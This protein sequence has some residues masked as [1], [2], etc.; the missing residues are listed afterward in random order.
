MP[1]SI[2]SL[3]IGAIALAL[4]MGTQAISAA[5]ADVPESKEPI[6]IVIMGYSGDNII[7]YI[8]GDL[9]EKLNYDV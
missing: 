8:L 7:M 1:K 5:K 6:K 2:R 9:L 3:T 4:V